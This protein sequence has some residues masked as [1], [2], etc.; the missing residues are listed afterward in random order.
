MLMSGKKDVS[1]YIHVPFC[2][3]KCPYCHFYS[4]IDD[5]GLKNQYV[6]ALCQ[7]IERWRDTI[8]Q[9]EIVSVYFGGG[10]PF[11]LGPTRL[12]RLMNL[13][14]LQ[15]S[16]E[17][18]IEANPETT[19]PSLLLAYRALGVNR[20][21]IGAQS[22]S[23]RYLKTLHRAHSS[24]QTRKVLDEALT[25]GWNNISI[26][27][28]FDLPGM[29]LSTWENTLEEAC[30]LPIQHISL[31]NLVIEP[32]TAWFR[33]KEAIQS[34]MPKEEVS[35][36]MIQSA[37]TITQS[38]GFAQYEISAFAKDG[39]Y[40]RHNVGY[41]QGREFLGFGPSAFS[42]FGNSRFSNIANL[43]KYCQAIEQNTTTV[44][45]SE[46]I[47]P[48]QRLREMVA[49]GLRMNNGI[50]LSSLEERWGPA[51]QELTST[52]HRLVSLELL[53][54]HHDTFRL[55]NRGRLVYDAIAVEII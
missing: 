13:F 33:N 39:F 29:E 22:F 8:F 50:S 37:W 52:L 38:H 6:N 2:T 23:D 32:K 47:A 19:T 27:L 43:K 48:Q 44:E 12:E 15:N 25:A 26:D 17:I 10:T 21:S 1:L 3:H 35:T 54:Q 7:E 53:E 40:S 46:E 42:F 5:E 11:L 41:W 30:H 36:Q 28:M 45:T 34:L 16:T 51:N 9:R 18:T 31:Y 49:V 24:D 14:P 4:V 20:L 55:T